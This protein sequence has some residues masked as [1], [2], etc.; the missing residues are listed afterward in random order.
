MNI[1]YQITEDGIAFSYL[2]GVKGTLNC[3][4]V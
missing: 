2:N 4:D 3:T 1:E